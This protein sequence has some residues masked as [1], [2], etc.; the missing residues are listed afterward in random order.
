MPRH[1]TN[2]PYAALAIATLAILWRA[3]PI[4]A[5]PGASP[6]SEKLAVLL[7]T[8]RVLKWWGF[9]GADLVVFIPALPRG[10]R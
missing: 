6:Q 8:H 9:S 3:S 5:Q 2:F 4:A 10:P 1:R 7:S